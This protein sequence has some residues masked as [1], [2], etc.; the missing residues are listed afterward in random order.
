MTAL[1]RHHLQ[2]AAREPLA[3]ES[4]LGFFC[5]A[6][7]F[8]LRSSKTFFNDNFKLEPDGREMEREQTHKRLFLPGISLG[9]HTRYNDERKRD[10]SEEFVEG[11]RTTPLNKTFYRSVE[12]SGL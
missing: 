8:I 12:S 1:L 7:P 5:S 11:F 9:H 2:P 3:A 4:Y 6:S 10:E